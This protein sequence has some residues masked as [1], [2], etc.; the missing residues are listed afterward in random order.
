[1]VWLDRT[2]LQVVSKN[3][4]CWADAAA[5][6]AG[7]RVNCKTLRLDASI[8]GGFIIHR[9]AT[10]DAYQVQLKPGIFPQDQAA[11]EQKI[12]RLRAQGQSVTAEDIDTVEK[13]G[14]ALSVKLLTTPPEE[15]LEIKR[16]NDYTFNF[17]DMFSDRGDVIN[18]DMPR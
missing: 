16:L 14:E 11:L 3:G 17:T 8:G 13:M 10:G 5:F 6:L 15:I 7:A 2:D 1:M 4:P 9:M 12:R 18:K